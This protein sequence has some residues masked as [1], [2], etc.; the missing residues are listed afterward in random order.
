MVAKVLAS[1][2]RP[3]RAGLTLVPDEDVTSTPQTSANA[4]LDPQHLAACWRILE[5]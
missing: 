5:A 2:R 1:G 4:R 3:R